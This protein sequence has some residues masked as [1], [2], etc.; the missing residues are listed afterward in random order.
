MTKGRFYKMDILHLNVPSKDNKI[1]TS[2]NLPKE[3]PL[4]DKPFDG[5]VI[6]K[7]FNFINEDGIIK[8]DAEIDI[9]NNLFQKIEC[10]VYDIKPSII[11][12]KSEEKDG[13]KIIK[14]CDFMSMSLIPRMDTKRVKK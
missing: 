1:I 5:G 2:I 12:K 7:T 4:K 10:G 13:M 14:K 8:C 6:G 3:M 11:I 9:E